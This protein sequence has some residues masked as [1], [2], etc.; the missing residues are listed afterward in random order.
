MNK[1]EGGTLQNEAMKRY[2]RIRYVPREKEERGRVEEREGDGKHERGW[3]EGGVVRPRDQ[4]QLCE[5]DGNQQEREV[6]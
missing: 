3:R 1:R 2:L 5:E 6:R 4:R